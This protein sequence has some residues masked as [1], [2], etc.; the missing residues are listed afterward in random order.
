[1]NPI[2]KIFKG[3]KTETTPEQEA[4]INAMGAGDPEQEELEG[5]IYGKDY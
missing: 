3:K 4:E 2:K 1:M 5:E